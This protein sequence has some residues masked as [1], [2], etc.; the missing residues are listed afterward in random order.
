MDPLLFDNAVYED[1]K[2]KSSRER[3]DIRENECYRKVTSTTINRHE[4]K[5]LSYSNVIIIAFVIVF[6]L[7]YWALLVHV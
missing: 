4:K 7:L 1:V 5:N 6:A 3:F 2:V